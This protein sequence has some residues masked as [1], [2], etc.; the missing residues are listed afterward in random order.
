[1]ARRRIL[2]VEDEILLGDDCAFCVEDAGFEVA[3]PYSRLKDVPQ[4]LLG[5]SGAILDVNIGGDTAY[6][7]VDRLLKMSIPVIIYTGYDVRR[8]PQEYAGL[9]RVMK[10]D[11][12]HEAVRKLIRHFEK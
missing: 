6:R 9:P 5:I 10:P 7:L 2:I 3:G 1:M 11:P 12:C 4:D 8:E